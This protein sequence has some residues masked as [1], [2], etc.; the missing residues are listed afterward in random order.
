MHAF[1]WEYKILLWYDRFEVIFPV[2][3]KYKELLLFLGTR[4]V[5]FGNFNAFTT[6]PYW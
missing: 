1:Y 3:I 2:L 6:K 5:G 4:V